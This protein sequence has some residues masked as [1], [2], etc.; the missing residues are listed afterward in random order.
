[1]LVACAGG[2]RL[3]FGNGD[4]LWSALVIPAV[5]V[6]LAITLTRNAWVS[7]A[8]G[9]AVLLAL[10]DRRLLRPMPIG[11]VLFVIARSSGQ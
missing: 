4:R 9:I 5:L 7:T 6:A 2:A 8:V 11:L 3:L 10:K 1:M